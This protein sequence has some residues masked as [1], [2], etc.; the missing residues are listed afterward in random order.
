MQVSAK[1][2]VVVS[3]TK[4]KT[5]GYIRSDTMTCR[6]DGGDFIAGICKK[7]A[8]AD[9]LVAVMRTTTRRPRENKGILTA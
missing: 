2:L 7:Q 9:A 8:S 3:K 5:T 4:E 6:P 1:T